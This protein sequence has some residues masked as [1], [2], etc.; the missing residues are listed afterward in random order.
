MALTKKIE[1]IAAFRLE[2]GKMAGTTIPAWSFGGNSIS[3]LGAGHGIP[4]LSGQHKGMVDTVD[5]DS[6]EGVAFRDLP[7]QSGIGANVD[8]IELNMRYDGLDRLLYWAFG[9]EDGGTSPVDKT[10]GIYSHLFELDRNERE[11]TAYRSDEDQAVGQSIYDRKNRFANFARKMGTND[12]RYPFLLC[13][14]FGFSSTTQEPL[15]MT[16]KGVALRED[17]GNYASANWTIPALLSGSDNIIMHHDLTLSI[18]VAGSLVEVGIKDISVNCDIP[19]DID[20][21]SE[22]GLY[23]SKPIL[24]G[25]YNV[26][27]SMTIAR[28]SVDT[29]LAYR[30]AHTKCALK[31][32]WVSD[33]KMFALYFP[34]VYLPDVSVTEDDVARIAITFATGKPSTTPFSTETTGHS[35]IQNGDFFCMTKNTNNTNEMR[36]E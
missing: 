33:T 29:Y 2:M 26:T 25:K 35:L 19:L 7:V 32:E 6:I 23:I 3:V 31:A 10:G 30:D 11:D 20:R 4:I 22:S 27:L 34:E 5:D 18:G 9:Y 17:R 12:Y 21:D 24:N 14:G 28:H 16:V 1:S 36:R 13:N 15:K 8:G